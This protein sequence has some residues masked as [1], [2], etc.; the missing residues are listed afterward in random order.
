[1]SSLDSLNRNCGPEIKLLVEIKLQQRS[2]F[3][4]ICKTKQSIVCFITSVMTSVDYSTRA[5]NALE[6]S[7]KFK[8]SEHRYLLISIIHRPA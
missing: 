4:V 3:H 5:G 1:M 2:P 6:R 7:L 8:F